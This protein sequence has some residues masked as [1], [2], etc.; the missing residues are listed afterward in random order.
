MNLYYSSLIGGFAAFL[1]AV[2]IILV[3][4][5]AIDKCREHV[6]CD[7]DWSNPNYVA[8]HVRKRY[9]VHGKSYRVKIHCNNKSIIEENVRAGIK[10]EMTNTYH[11]Y[12]KNNEGNV[13]ML[14][15]TMID[16]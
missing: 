6:N 9:C 10:S 15:M 12:L 11:L 3:I 14:N 8:V 7:L 1:V 2:I 5:N 4:F 13:N 16:P